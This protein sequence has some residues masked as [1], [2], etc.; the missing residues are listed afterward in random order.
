MEET[1]N[2]YYESYENLVASVFQRS[3]RRKLKKIFT[4]SS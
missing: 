4:I 3:Q 2:T 1:T